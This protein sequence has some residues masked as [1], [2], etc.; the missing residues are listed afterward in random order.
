MTKMKIYKSLLLACIVGLFFACDS[1]KESSNAVDLTES[2]ASAVETVE[3]PQEDAVSQEKST[4]E[5]VAL[6][7]EHGKPGHRCD[8]PVGAPLDSPPSTGQ[9]QPQ[10]VPQQSN[11]FMQYGG[12]NAAN[13]NPPHGEPGHRC[14]IPVGAPLS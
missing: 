5:T 2:Q 10:A 7:P 9:V 1:K 4:A 12:E 14:D 13:V 11:P 6:N 8:I 3:S